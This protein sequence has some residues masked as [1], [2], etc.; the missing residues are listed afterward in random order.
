MLHEIRS[1]VNH[2]ILFEALT[3][4]TFDKNNRY[5]C[6]S[7]KDIVTATAG[8]NSFKLGITISVLRAYPHGTVLR[9]KRH[10]VRIFYM[11]KFS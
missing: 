9:D 8:M 1:N 7:A 6:K 5:M 3:Q 2:T 10:Y 4:H 11:S